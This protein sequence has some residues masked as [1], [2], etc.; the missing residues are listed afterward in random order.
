MSCFRFAGTRRW[1]KF[2][3]AI[4]FTRHTLLINESALFS[5]V[6]DIVG[7]SSRRRSEENFLPPI[8]RLYIFAMWHKLKP[9]KSRDWDSSS[10]MPL[11]LTKTR[12]LWCAPAFDV[13]RV[14]KARYLITRNYVR[15]TTTLIL[16][17][18]SLG[19]LLLNG[20]VRRLVYRWP[21]YTYHGVI[22]R[23]KRSL[24]QKTNRRAI[25]C[26]SW[27]C[28]KNWKSPLWTGFKIPADDLGMPSP[29]EGSFYL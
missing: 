17:W 12:K 5:T 9:Q 2:N 10:M 25:F 23:E 1:A 7:A 24:V 22:D 4:P 29:H 14:R 13:L 20:A 26:A 18:S 15:Q 16:P 11:T 28:G 19:D 8:A 6:F 27:I 21:D 3:Y